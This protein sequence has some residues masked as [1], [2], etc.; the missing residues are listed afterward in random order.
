MTRDCPIVDFCWA[1]AYQGIREEGLAAIA[2]AFARQSER[3]A[4]SQTGGELSLQ[5]AASLYLESLIN[6]F[7]ADAHCW[8]LGEVHLQ[9]LCD[10]LRAPGRGPAS[11][12]PANSAP[13]F[14]YHGRPVE[15]D[16]VWCGNEAGEPFLHV[17]AQGGV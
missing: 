6:G 9:A 4:G 10:L 2:C 8:L 17:V 7:V 3:S 1:V 15:S 14:P 11:A 12:L 13:P 16:A 5:G